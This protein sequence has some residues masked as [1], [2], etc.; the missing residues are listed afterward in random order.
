MPAIRKVK[1]YIE[2]ECE[3]CLCALEFLR[4]SF[5]YLCG[6]FSIKNIEHEKIPRAINSEM[7]KENVTPNCTSIT[8]K[9]VNSQ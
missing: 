9:F 4:F 2:Y 6:Y 3:K 8:L 5:S 1:I 7:L